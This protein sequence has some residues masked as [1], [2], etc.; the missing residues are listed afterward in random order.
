MKKYNLL[1]FNIITILFFDFIF[2]I[3]IFNNLFSLSTIILILFDI[4]L[5]LFITL[6]ESI[7]NNKVICKIIIT[8]TTLFIWLLFTSQ[9][10]YYQYY[11]TVFS[12]YSMFNGAQVFGF[13]NSIIRVITENIIPIL[14]LL[15]PIISLF[16]GINKFTLERKNKKYYIITF[17]GLLFSYILPILLINLSK[18]TKTYSTYNLYYNT[19]VPKLIT[20]DLGVLNEMRIDLKR[21][22]FKT[23]ENIE[24]NNNNN[25][26]I[27]YSSEEYNVLDIDF[28]ELIENEKDE[29]L[30]KMHE[31]F[32]N[33]KPTMKN[34]YTGIFK[35]KNLIVIIA[36]SAS[37]LSIDKNLTPTL[38]KL[39][40]NGFKFNNFYTPL[41]SIS[42]SDGEYISLTSLLPKEGTWSMPDS[43]NNYLPFVYGNIFKRNGYVAN[44]YHDGDY[45]YYNRNKSHPNMGYNYKGC[46]GGLKINCDYF[47]ESD[48]EMIEQS[49]KDYI[50]ESLF[51]TYYMTVSGHLEYNYKDNIIAR[52]NKKYVEDLNYDESIKAYLAT[53]IELDKAVE[54]LIKELEKANKLDDTVIVISADHYPY[55]LSKK[56]IKQNTNYI[57]DE[58]FDI[59]KNNFII[60]NNKL[61]E[62]IEINKF[63]SS[64]DIL[65]TILNLFGINY[66]SRILMGKDLLSNENGLVIYNDRSFITD[67]GKY[68]SVTNTFI[69]FVNNVDNNYVEKTNEIVNNKF[70]I[71]KLILERDYY[72]KIYKIKATSK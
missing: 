49:I 68:N 28:D 37:P 22:I 1:I 57:K 18:D 13:L 39:Y 16:F 70:I 33:E 10:V 60:W 9:F 12:I 3:F 5:G 50:N 27:Y 53:Q 61:K 62:S 52:K 40:N 14:I 64:L 55:G 41:Y 25:K 65:P 51:I 71:S 17:T 42:T 29:T 15:I 4:N 19:Y 44:A 30:I 7:I 21:M 56:A 32:K 8:I 58:K 48:I 2:K 35:D 11:E 54:L 31:Y 23:D 26:N 66:D 24:F 63:G 46:N 72:R 67:K 36:E 47:P 38:Y 69:P 34:K 43:S 6:L 59:H 20:K 45:N